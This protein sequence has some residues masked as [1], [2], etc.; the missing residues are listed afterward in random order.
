MRKD[1]KQPQFDSISE[2]NTLL[3][4]VVNDGVIIVNTQGMIIECNPAFH[5]RLGYEKDEV[6]GKSVQQLD[7]PEFAAKVPQRMN[8]ILQNGHAV[9]ETA[10]YRKDGSIM[11]IE[12]NARMV[13][14]KDQVL[15]LSIV[16]D[17]AERKKM[18]A[19]LDEKERMY[20]TLLKTSADGFWQTDSQGRLVDV[21]EAYIQRSGY[22]REELLNMRIPDLEAN[23]SPEETKQ[24]IEKIIRTGHGRFETWHRTKQ[25]ELWPVEIATTYL[26]TNGGMFFVFCT[27]ISERKRA[28][29][30]IVAQQIELSKLSQALQQAGEGIIITDPSGR[31][32]YVNPAFSQ[33]TGYAFHEAVGQP[34]SILKSDAQDPAIYRKLWQT[35]SAGNN[36]EGTLI[37]RRKDGSFYPAMI[38]IAPVFN[39][40]NEIIH[41]VSIQKDITELKK[42]E[43]QLVQAQKMESMGTLVGGIAHDF[44]NMLA[45]VQGNIFLAIRELNNPKI[46]NKKLQTINELTGRASGIVKQLLT[47]AKKDIVDIET[48]DLNTVILD[49]FKLARSTIPENISHQIVICEE[50]LRVNGDVTQLQQVMINLSNNARDALDH[51]SQPR[52]DWSLKR[53][54]A[55][56]AFRQKHPKTDCAEFALLSLKDNGCGIATPHLKAIYD[57]FFTTKE[58]GKGTGLGLSMVFGSVERHGG[59]LEVES[60]PGQG[61]SFHIYL[62]LVISSVASNNM[63]PQVTVRGNMETILLAD[64]EENLLSTTSE[65]LQELGYHVIEATNGE[66]ALSLYIQHR[67]Q[68]DLILSDIVMPGI[69]GVELASEIRKINSDIPIILATGYD[70]ELVTSGKADIETCRILTKPYAFEELSQIIHQMISSE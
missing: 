13:K 24:H 22:T 68:I 29:Q 50:T 18:H 38:S 69:G 45:A 64:D 41:Y 21:N 58:P 31:I 43:N 6:I 16:R 8:Q 70:R 52:I 51:V 65:V 27:D 44:N 49:G 48:L 26:P 66:Q 3:F 15:C 57:P 19:A 56:K 47:F 59:I 39:D 11:P 2:L 4:E 32:E 10:H 35:I 34:T 37:D 30:E 36:W 42:M 55:T 1:D 28:Q 63:Q 25:G 33:N 5:Q 62:P 46:V 17:I 7:P 61:T 54:I 23:E 14:I 9:F 60:C 67:G 40:K 53:Y 20:T 12:I